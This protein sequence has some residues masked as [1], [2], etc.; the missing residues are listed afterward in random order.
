LA[1][2]QLDGTDHILEYGDA[3][4]ATFKNLVTKDGT[5][6]SAVNS[7]IVIDTNFTHYKMELT[8]STATMWLGGILEATKTNHLPTKKIGT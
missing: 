8:S 1:D 3:S 5:T 2:G 4:T 6:Q 7:S